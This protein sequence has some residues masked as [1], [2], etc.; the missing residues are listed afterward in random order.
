MIK[1]FYG[2]DRVRAQDAVREFLGGDYEVIEG[3]E[4]MN[5][6]LPSLLAGGSLFAMERRI[7]IRD[8]LDNKAVAEDLPKYLDTVHR[9][10]I[11]E[12]KVDKRSA[13]YKA[14]KDKMEFREF[15]LA[16]DKNAGVIFDIYKVAKR[17]GQ[18]AVEMLEQI[19]DGQEPMMF[20]GLM[21]S[22]AI[23]DYAKRPGEAE[24]RA[25]GKLSKL[26]MD[27]KSS[28]IQPWMLIEAFLLRLGK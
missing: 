18:K 24:K 12:M 17:D 20:L 25:L 22:Q 8:V 19:K 3:G 21:V 13:T 10:A 11:L 5:A 4:L 27:L 16:K 2:E 7:L 26:D 14:L 23:R 9:V 28:K 6:D 15:E 1:V